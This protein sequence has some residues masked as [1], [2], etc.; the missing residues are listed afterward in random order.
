M[1]ALDKFCIND[2]RL[3]GQISKLTN[4]LTGEDA[5]D[6]LPCYFFILSLPEYAILSST[7]AFLFYICTTSSY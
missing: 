1:A 4:D 5:G 6:D 2:I 3:Y 7:V